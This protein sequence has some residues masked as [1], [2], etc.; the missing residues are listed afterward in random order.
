MN[1][2]LP[3]PAASMA[4]L[5]SHGP[6]L[7]QAGGDDGLAELSLE[8]LM[9]LDVV[10]TS[11][12]RHAQPLSRT[13]AAVYVIGADD[14]ARSGASSIPEVLRL[15]PGVHVARIDSS[16][17]AVSIRGFND[18]FANKLL[19]LLDGRSVYTPL[20]SGT[21]WDAL[22]V[23]LA[24]IERI[25]VVRGPGGPLWGANAVNGVINIITKSSAQTSGGALELRAGDF[26]RALGRVRYGA[27]DERGGWR[28][29]GQ[30]ADRGPTQVQGGAEGLDDWDLGHAGFR[31]DRKLTERDELLVLGHAY[32]GLI[33]SG[34]TLAAPPPL[35]VS[36]GRSRSNAAG[37]SLQS[38]WT[39]AFEDGG[40]FML[41]G[42]VDYSERELDVSLE[43]RSNVFVEA[44][45]RWRLGVHDLTV[46]AS[47]RSTSA[48]VRN[49]FVF[50]LASPE[51]T[52][53][54]TSVFAQDEIELVPERWAL[55]LGARVEQEDVVGAYAQPSVRLRYTP[56]EHNTFWAALSHSVRTPSQVEQDIAL[57]V[58]AIP[59]PPDQFA[60]YFGSRDVDPETVD[61]VELGYRARPSER[62]TVDATAYFKHYSDLI[63]FQAGA[64]FASGADFIVPFNARNV[65]QADSY[66]FELALEWLARDDTRLELAWTSQQL[67][68]RAE[69]GASPVDQAEEGNTPSSNLR[70][71]VRHD[72]NALWGA[73]LLVWR[74]E[75][76]DNGD[77]PA[78]WR[79]DLAV[80]RR[81]E[82]GGRLSFGAQNLFHDG[83]REFGTNL[84]GATNESVAALFVRLELGF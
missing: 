19:V 70:L 10:V 36:S 5:L 48:D 20:F 79:L 35:Y 43:Q 31:V 16:R 47:V 63:Q 84:F 42:Y 46:G 12:T 22:D 9:Q 60:T 29:W 81:L 49:G 26:D 27:T 53:S 82:H 6:L 3:I 55:I 65:A 69:G 56:D 50:T 64:P 71:G 1:S 44:Q 23:P 8:Q 45:R 73:D 78:Y 52:I 33:D 39:R 57:V 24:D 58:A 14:I 41:G 54:R 28:A 80:Q 67:D 30:I 21:W 15:A 40:E 37:A 25:E 68:L 66:G 32:Q 61:A 2:T 11:A 59:G 17:W 76:L 7:A 62:V 72:L 38:R 75:A 4:L 18:Q 83:E 77:V 13:A 51:R 74:V 34:Q